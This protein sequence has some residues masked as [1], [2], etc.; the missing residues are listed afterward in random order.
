MRMKL[1]QVD[2]K[3]EQTVQK[4]VD[5]KSKEYWEPVSGKHLIGEEHLSA[6]AIFAIAI[7]FT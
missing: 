4:A 5:A 2:D 7:F 1:F 3:G 6:I